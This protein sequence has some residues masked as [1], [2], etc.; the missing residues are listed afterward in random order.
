M[1]EY[2]ILYILKP[3][4]SA[5]ALK[6]VNEKVKEWITSTGGKIDLYNEM[7][8]RDIATEFQKFNTG[9]YVQIQFTCGQPTLNEL[10]EKLAVTEDIFRH[11]IVTMASIRPKKK[12]EVTQ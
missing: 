7:G 3:T 11:L 9:Y 1:K 8:L 10:H 4:L 2:E 12:E 5:D 6:S